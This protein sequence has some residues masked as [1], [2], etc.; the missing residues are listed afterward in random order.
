MSGT[1]LKKIREQRGFETCTD[2]SIACNGDPSHSTIY[3]IE[4]NAIVN[5]GILTLKKLANVLEC[6]LDDFGFKIDQQE[7]ARD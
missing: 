6:T 3:K 7:A 2:L 1:N 4:T 5:P